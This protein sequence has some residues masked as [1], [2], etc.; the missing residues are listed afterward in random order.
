MDF[1]ISFALRL[2][3]ILLLHDIL[4]GRYFSKLKHA[5]LYGRVVKYNTFCLD[6]NYRELFGISTPVAI[7]Q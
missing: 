5:V 3:D 4:P 1:I 6:E 7:L 2:D